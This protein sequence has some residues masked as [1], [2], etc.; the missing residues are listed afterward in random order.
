MTSCVDTKLCAFVL[1][2]RKFDEFAKGCPVEDIPRLTNIALES[3]C[4]L[5]F[6]L[7]HPG[8]PCY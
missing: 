8:W 7:P 3:C 2:G 4:F 1:T 5:T 6:C